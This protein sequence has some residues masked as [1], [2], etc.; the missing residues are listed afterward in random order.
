VVVPYDV[1]SDDP[2]IQRFTVTVT[3]PPHSGATTHFD[4]REMLT[5]DLQ[6]DDQCL[7]EVEE[8]D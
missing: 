8:N 1:M 7:V 4:L 6:F 5:S 2:V 3:K